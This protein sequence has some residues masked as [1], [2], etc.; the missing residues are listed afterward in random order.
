MRLYFRKVF[1]L[2][3]LRQITVIGL[4]LLGGSISSGILRCF[5]DVK[6]VGYAHRQ[7]TRQKAAE[8]AV[9]SEIADSLTQSVSHADIV[10]LA[11]P[12]GIFEN[13]FKEISNSL[14]KGC[15]VTDVGSTKVLP[16]HWAKEK[17]PDTVF[18]VGSHPIAGSENRGVEFSRDDLLDRAVCILTTTK[19]TNSQ[20]VKTLECFW[21]KLGCSVKLMEPAEHDATFANISHLPHVAAASLVNAT[22]PK[23]ITFAGKGFLDT[24]RIASGPADIW[25]D[26]ILSNESNI[27]I[28]IDKLIEELNRLKKAIQSGQKEQVEHF[29]KTA[30]EKRAELIE[31]KMKQKEVI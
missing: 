6:V 27:I 2:K 8:L 22:S 1:I 31:Y 9:A 3:D 16:H 20:A 25:V 23:D 7:S 13:I 18:Y 5:P 14:P 11:T 15:I 29:L 24:T 4:G 10:I 17:L 30:R 12:I 19:K 21:K 28:G 26:V